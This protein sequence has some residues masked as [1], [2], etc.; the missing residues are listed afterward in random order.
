[1][2]LKFNLDKNII[3]DTLKTWS[4]NYMTCV[5][6][7]EFAEVVQAISKIERAESESKRRNDKKVLRNLLEEELADV[8]ICIENMITSGVVKEKNIQM[9]I[10][11]KQKRQAKRNKEKQKMAIKTLQ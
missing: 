8:I 4:H 11:M 10:D 5:H 3:K 2:K 1:M 9:W 6:M 7:E